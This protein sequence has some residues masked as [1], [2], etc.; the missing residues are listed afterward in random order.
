MPNDV[1]EILKIYETVLGY[2]AEQTIKHLTRQ[3]ND[4]QARNTELLLLARELN[5]KLEK[6]E[7][8]VA[9]W[10]NATEELIKYQN[11]FEM[12]V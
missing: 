3:R 12:V 6:S 5:A 7:A 2:D 10:K 11:N 8:M 4:L 1:E 9:V